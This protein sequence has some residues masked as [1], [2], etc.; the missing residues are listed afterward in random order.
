[1]STSAM[2]AAMQRVL[3]Q[4]SHMETRLTDAM[5]GHCGELERR[6]HNSEQ[7]AEAW[8]ISLKMD[9]A[10]IEDW[11]PEV[12]KR[13]ENITLELARATKFLERG[14]FAVD[15]SKMGIIHSLGSASRRPSI[16]L[17]FADGPN[18][19]HMEHNH[20]ER[21]FGRITPQPHDPVKGKHPDPHLQGIGAV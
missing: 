14:A 17:N 13:I 12:E 9:Q 5:A 20:R 19:H 15:S 3:D 6:I 4:L 10:Q 8:F 2:D 11:P 1:V 7:K 18:G 21:E 16:E